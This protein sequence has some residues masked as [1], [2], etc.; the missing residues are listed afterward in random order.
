MKPLRAART[1]GRSTF[2]QLNYSGWGKDTTTT[3]VILLSTVKEIG[4]NAF[5][6]FTALTSVEIP[7]GV[8]RIGDFAFDGCSALADVELPDALTEIGELAF[9]DTALT[10]I[11]IPEN[12]EEIGREA[13]D[14]CE[15]LANVTFSG[16]KLRT[17]AYC[18][19][20]ECPI[21]EIVLPDGLETIGDSSLGDSLQSITFPD[22]IRKVNMYTFEYTPWYKALPD[23]E[24]VYI[25]KC[26]CGFKTDQ[27][28]DT[29]TFRPDTKAIS[30]M[31][32]VKADHIVIPDGVKYLAEKAFYSKSFKTVT[33]PDSVQYIGDSCFAENEHLEKVVFPKEVDYFG[34]DM[35]SITVGSTLQEIDRSK[36][37]HELTVILPENLT[38]IPDH[39]FQ[40]CTALYAIS[41]PS[42]VKRIGVGA[43]SGCSWLE[44]VVIP[45]GVEIIDGGGSGS[46]SAGQGKE[47]YK[48]ADNHITK[49]ELLNWYSDGAFGN[50]P[51]LASI[52][53]PDSLICLGG[54]VF[55][56]TK[57][58]SIDLKNVKYIGDQCFG[59]T[60]LE[61]I[62]VPSSV[63]SIGAAAFEYCFLLESV[64]LPDTLKYVDLGMFEG[65]SRLKTI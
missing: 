59:Y 18:T 24:P 52:E 37:D 1:S 49:I 33:I 50:C 10:S 65:C 3:D 14:G 8:T 39:T 29:F 38:E 16:N 30:S 5:K 46:Y 4:C 57:I 19:F 25:G 61:S 21:E 56:N 63:K 31:F 28:F 62:T 55:D 23:D 27:T 47:V 26:F 42:G 6:D 12:V 13:F 35:F 60:P 51:S 54:S 45:E 53:L 7:E 43:F 32:Q 48:D 64:V 40:N 44:S 15:S 34:S 22:S 2:P 58:T 11:T 9:S 17:L 20:D 36:P 41:I